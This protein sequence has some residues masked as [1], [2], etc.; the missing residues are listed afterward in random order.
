MDKS[1]IGGWSALIALVVMMNAAMAWGRTNSAVT[2]D[3]PSHVEMITAINDMS[4]E[5]STFMSA[6]FLYGKDVKDQR[7]STNGVMVAE[8]M[9]C[10]QCRGKCK[11]EDPKCRSQCAGES[12]CLAH[13]EELSSTCEAMCKQ[14][15]QCE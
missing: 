11:A 15:F 3:A 1:C 13:C 2:V 5:C 14:I 4:A 7:P 12:A 10:R 8:D 6:E 9:R